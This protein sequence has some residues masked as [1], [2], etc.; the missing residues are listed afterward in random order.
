MALAVARGEAAAEMGH[1]KVVEEAGVEVEEEVEV[2][3]VD[4]VVSL[5]WHLETNS[6]S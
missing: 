1:G 5:W 6:I 3:V 4:L 2:A